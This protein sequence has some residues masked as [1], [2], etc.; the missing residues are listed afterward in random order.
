MVVLNHPIRLTSGDNLWNDA[1]LLDFE[2]V[3][4]DGTPATLTRLDLFFRVYPPNPYWD[5]K[6]GG[7]VG[8]GAP[9]Y[10]PVD[11]QSGYP[12][13]FVDMRDLVETRERN[14]GSDWNHSVRARFPID[15]F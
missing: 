15:N 7:R 12:Q 3:N 8:S 4:S 10:P 13:P 9:S 2:V 14:Q 5:P 1:K 11:S 6:Q